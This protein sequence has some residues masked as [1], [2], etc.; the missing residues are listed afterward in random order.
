[1]TGLDLPNAVV[2]VTGASA[3]IGRAT[4]L[5]FAGRGSTVVAAARRTDILQELAAE[6]ERTGARVLPVA[7]DVADRTQV[8]ALADRVHDAFGRCDVLVNNAGVPG[9]GPFAHASIEGIEHI[10]RVNYLGVL[11][12]TKAFL[13]MMLQAGR[14]HIVNVASIAGRFATPGSAVYSSTK[15]AVVAFSEALHYEVAPRGLKVTAVNPGF[16]RTETFRPPS[17]RDRGGLPLMEPETVADLIVRVVERGIAP[18]R[19]IPRW[20][21]ALQAVRILAPPLY[22]AGMA[23]AARGKRLTRSPRA[24]GRPSA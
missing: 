6:V 7:C 13:S 14:G 24:P 20:L 12:C 18:E 2:V 4:A 1:M 5:A 8:Q 10:T 19:S 17:R 9:S 15:H 21:A 3:G 23:R 11:Y 16:V 22:R